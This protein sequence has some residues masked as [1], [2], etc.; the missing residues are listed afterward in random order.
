M[1]KSLPEKS[2]DSQ[3]FG[4]KKRSGEYNR[5]INGIRD[6]NDV[7]IFLSV[8]SGAKFASLFLSTNAV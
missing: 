1:T 5:V 2:N 6:I 3:I 4:A 8:N 7:D